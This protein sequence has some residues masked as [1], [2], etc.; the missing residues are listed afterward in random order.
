MTL[1]IDPPT[2]W[3]HGRNWSHLISDSSI[4]ELHQF[5]RSAGIR[6]LS[7]GFD[8]YDVPEELFTRVTGLGVQVVDPRV[9]VR[10]LRTSGLRTPLGK[11]AKRWS[12]T[13]AAERR[14]LWSPAA[15]ASLVA[16]VVDALSAPADDVEI[17]VRPSEVAIVATGTTDPTAD[18]G[19]LERLARGS[20]LTGEPMAV[21]AVITAVSSGWALELVM[22]RPA[23][24]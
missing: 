13:T 14:E 4:E 21:T 23:I 20:W 1:Y 17:V 3:F 15:E 6:Y 11:S 2:W 8:H 12:R 16:A 22:R 19:R 10:T 18:A 9:I 5:A 7:F 24:S